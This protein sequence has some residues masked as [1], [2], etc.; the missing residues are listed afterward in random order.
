VDAVRREIQV[1]AHEVYRHGAFSKELAVLV[2]RTLAGLAVGQV[3]YAV[4]VLLR[5]SLFDAGAPRAV[6][7]AAAVLLCV[8]WIGSRP[9]IHPLGLR[10][11]SSLAALTTCAFLLVRVARL[12]RVL[13]ER[14]E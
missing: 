9:V 6:C 11:A 5:Q 4:T 14:G 10:V 1:P 8:K 7:E 12:A 2:S 13:K 3:V